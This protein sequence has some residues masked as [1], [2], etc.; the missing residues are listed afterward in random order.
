MSRNI[1]DTV[2]IISESTMRSFEQRA[3]GWRSPL[4]LSILQSMLVYCGMEAT[5]TG[6][7]DERLDRY[8]IDVDGNHYMWDE[9]CFEDI[10]DFDGLEGLL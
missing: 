6:I 5:I 4:G 9:S 2:R 3:Y 10:M 1:G 7:F 8:L